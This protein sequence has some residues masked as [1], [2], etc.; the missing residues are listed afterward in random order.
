MCSCSNVLMTGGVLIGLHRGG[1]LVGN[2]YGGVLIGLH[3]EVC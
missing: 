2:H 3:R 1:V